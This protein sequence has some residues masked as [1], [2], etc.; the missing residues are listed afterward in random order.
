MRRSP[1]RRYGPEARPL[2][3]LRRA[4]GGEWPG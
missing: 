2:A 4:N 1:H 3:R